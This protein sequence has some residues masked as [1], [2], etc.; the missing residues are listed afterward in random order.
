[1]AAHG[2]RPIVVG[3]P[4]RG[5]NPV[6]VGAVLAQAVQPAPAPP[7]A[8]HRINSKKLHI[9]LAALEVDEVSNEDCL[10]MAQAKGLLIEFSIGD[11]VHA[12]PADPLRSRH[13]HMYVHFNAPIQHRDGTV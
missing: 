5:Q 13:K 9:T 4:L 8:E 2:A 12:N 1:M 7:S 3:L 6:P 10:R 11:E